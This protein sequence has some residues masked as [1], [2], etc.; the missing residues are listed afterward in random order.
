MHTFRTV[1][2]LDSGLES[3][4]RWRVQTNSPENVD[5]LVKT[6][7]PILVAHDQQQRKCKLRTSHMYYFVN[8]KVNFAYLRRTSGVQQFCPLNIKF[9]E[10]LLRKHYVQGIPDQ[11][12][13]R[14]PIKKGEHFRYRES[15]R[16]SMMCIEQKKSTR[17]YLSSTQKH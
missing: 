15:Y 16:K 8:H 14:I 13:R 4:S 11:S 17:C 10:V 6:Q 3:E 9:P 2:I 7:G 12:T 1:S 5:L